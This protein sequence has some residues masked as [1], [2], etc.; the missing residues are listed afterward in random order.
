MELLQVN[1]LMV[2][3]TMFN[4]MR[5]RILGISRQKLTVLL[6][7]E[8]AEKDY[9]HPPQFDAE[10]AASGN[11]TP[12]TQSADHFCDLSKEEKAGAKHYSMTYSDTGTIV[13]EILPDGVH[14]EEA[15]DTAAALGA[16]S[17]VEASILTAPF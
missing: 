2:V 14:I 15:L 11:K 7:H 12:F 17:T 6:T 16:N 1:A 9:D 3:G 4:S 5:V 8:A 10:P 13:C